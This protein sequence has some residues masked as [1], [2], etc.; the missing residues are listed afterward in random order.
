MEDGFLCVY[1]F[2]C[3]VDV[4]WEAVADG[5]TFWAVDVGAGD[6]GE[7]TFYE[8]VAE[9]CYVGVFFV[10]LNEVECFRESYDRRCVVGAGSHVEFMHSAVD[11]GLDLCVALY[12]E[13]GYSFRTVDFTAIYGHHIEIQSFCVERFHSDSLARVRVEICFVLCQN[14]PDFFYRFNGSDFVIRVHY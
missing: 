10:F 3:D 8:F 2:D 12:V 4:V 14:S 11:E 7:Q 13:D 1:A 6:F 5:F 9:F